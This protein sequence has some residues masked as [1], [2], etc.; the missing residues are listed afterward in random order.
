MFSRSIFSDSSFPMGLVLVKNTLMELVMMCRCFEY[1]MYMRKPRM[2]TMCDHRN[3]SW[4]RF[5]VPSP[6][7]SKIREMAF[8][9]GIHS[10][11]ESV[12][13]STIFTAFRARRVTMIPRIIRR[14]KS[15]SSRWLPMNR[16]SRLTFRKYRA[17]PIPTMTSTEKTSW[18]RPSHP[19]RPMNGMANR[20]SKI[21]PNAS[22]IVVRRTRNPQK[23]NACIIPGPSRCRSFRCPRTTTASSSKRFGRS[24]RRRTGLPSLTRRKRVS[25]RRRKMPPAV[26]RRKRKMMILSTVRV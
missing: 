1:G 3:S 24:S 18:T 13:P 9:T 22:M 12:S 15:A 19:V 5:S 10:G 23:M 8:E 4:N 14:M 21:S 20:S 26:A 17:I 6:R 11:G 2:S 16:S 25:A 7:L